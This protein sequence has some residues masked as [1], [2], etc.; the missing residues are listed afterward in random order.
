MPVRDP[1]A[2]ALCLGLLAGPL[3]AALA[4]RG[5]RAG[6]ALLAAAVALAALVLTS[7]HADLPGTAVAAGAA[8]ACALLLPAA[9]RGGGGFGRA[10]GRAGF[11]GTFVEARLPRALAGAA[12]SALVDPADA[13]HLERA[14][15]DAEAASGAE[16]AVALVR[17]SSAYGAAGWRG[18]AWLAA[19]GLAAAAAL[20]PATPRLALAAA[21]AGALLGHAGARA[22]R[23][24]RFLVS[25]AALVE[26]AEARALDAF[27]RAGLGRAPG[28]A[29]VLLFAALFE[30]RVLVLADRGVAD[31]SGG[32]EDVARLGAA[33][34]GEDGRAAAPLARAL[35]RAGAVA[36]SAG[37]GAAAPAADRPPPILLED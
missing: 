22:P 23:L 5:V 34:L 7:E 15:L 29:G 11:A 37:R 18:A 13:L 12:P 33:A 19:L 27:A 10:F 21:A 35:E 30:G 20:A 17:R 6:G 31:A 16:L 2:F 3:G 32:W 26:R 1:L 25:E 8:S 36:A 4:R 14:V 28:H 9:L 24:R